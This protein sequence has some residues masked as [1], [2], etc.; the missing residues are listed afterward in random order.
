MVDYRFWK[1]KKKQVLGFRFLPGRLLTGFIAVLGWVL[2]F[3][4][5]PEMAWWTRLPV[6]MWGLYGIYTLFAF[7]VKEVKITYEPTYQG[8][9]NLFKGPRVEVGTRSLMGCGTHILSLFINSYL[10]WLSFQ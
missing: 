7:V 5:I 3:T 2:V 8:R 10:L 9:V 4:V 1:P 6:F